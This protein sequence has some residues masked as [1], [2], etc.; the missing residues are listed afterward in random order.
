GLRPLLHIPYH[1]DLF[2]EL[3]VERYELSKT[4]KILFNHPEGTHD[5]RFWA[6]ALATYAVEMEPSA[7]SLPIGRIIG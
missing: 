2:S 7:A 1:P 4:G 5:D 6:L 3:N